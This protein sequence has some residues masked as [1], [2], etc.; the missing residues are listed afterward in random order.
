MGAAL[1]L[2]SLCQRWGCHPCLLGAVWVHTGAN[3]CT[4]C[5]GRGNHPGFHPFPQILSF[6]AS[7]RRR[8][9]LV[10]HHLRAVLDFSPPDS[11]GLGTARGFVAAQQSWLRGWHLLFSRERPNLGQEYLCLFSKIPR[12]PERIQ[13]LQ[14]GTCGRRDGSCAGGS[15]RAAAF[16]GNR[17]LPA[18]V[19]RAGGIAAGRWILHLPGEQDSTLGSVLAEQGPCS[20]V[21]PSGRFAPE[22]RFGRLPLPSPCLHLEAQHRNPD[23]IIL[24]PE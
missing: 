14:V 18:G 15:T 6:P 8:M 17:G 1:C 11:A 3:G 23:S 19:G 13:P 24:K 12:G 2:Q 7:L 20:C 22:P 5:R 9:P 16:W 4:S 10:R 21:F